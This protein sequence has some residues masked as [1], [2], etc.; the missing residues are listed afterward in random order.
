MAPVGDRL[1]PSSLPML[2]FPPPPPPLLYAFSRLLPL[3]SDWIQTL[4]RVQFDNDSEN[5]ITNNNNSSSNN[6]SS[7]ENRR[8]GD[9]GINS[10]HHSRTQTASSSTNANATATERRVCASL[11]SRCLGARNSANTVV[12]K[13]LELRV[14]EEDRG[15][16]HPPA[17][18]VA[19]AGRGIRTKYKISNSVPGWGSSG[20]GGG[21][22]SVGVSAAATA[23]ATAIAKKR[24]RLEIG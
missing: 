3:L 21:W 24:P 7:R 4:S 1:C 10:S 19:V 17:A 8:G 6:S 14:D 5:I 12:S 18:L 2:S 11:L 23:T 13:F 15:S 22:G 20:K 9:E 16:G